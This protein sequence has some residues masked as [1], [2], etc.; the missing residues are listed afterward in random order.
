MHVH[1]QPSLFWL[2]LLW[3]WPSFDRND[4]LLSVKGCQKSVFLKQFQTLITLLFTVSRAGHGIT[5][6]GDQHHVQLCTK[7]YKLQFTIR[8]TF[9]H[10]VRYLEARPHHFNLSPFRYP[11]CGVWNFINFINCPSKNKQSHNDHI[12]SYSSISMYHVFL[13]FQI[14]K[15]WENE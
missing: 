13:A 3:Y 7:S 2:T 14:Q 6:S 12:L 10:R 5:F 8:L 4:I 1:P 9:A 15:N 11:S